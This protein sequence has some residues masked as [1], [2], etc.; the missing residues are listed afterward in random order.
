MNQSELERLLMLEIH[1]I[2]A[3]SS[4]SALL[5]LGKAVPDDAREGF[6]TAADIE[7]AKR[8]DPLDITHPV[9]QKSMQA[10][11]ARNA[12]LSYPPDGAI[13]DTDADA[14][15]SMKLTAAQELVLKRLIAQACECAFMKFFHL[16]DNVAAPKDVPPAQWQ[17]VH[18]KYGR[19][20]GDMLHDQFGQ[21]YFEF[22]QQRH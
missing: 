21:L 5:P 3:E 4:E 11:I 1:R 8:L 2:I 10:T 14:L 18:F 20:E 12:V 6:L 15:E 19:D 9:W 7:S 16:L 13:T 17:G 22:R